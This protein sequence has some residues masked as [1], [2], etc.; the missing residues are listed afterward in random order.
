MTADFGSYTSNVYNINVPIGDNDTA[1][2]TGAVCPCGDLH[3][4]TH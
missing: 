3:C 4:D 1:N 2:A